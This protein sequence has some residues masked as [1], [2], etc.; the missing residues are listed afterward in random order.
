M[1]KF[2]SEIGKVIFAFLGWLLCSVLAFIPVWSKGG[3]GGYSAVILSLFF[4]VVFF[5]LYYWL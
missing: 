3:S 1:E 4:L 2:D 5:L